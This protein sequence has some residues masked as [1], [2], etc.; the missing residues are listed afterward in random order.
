PLALAVSEKTRLT[1]SLRQLERSEQLQSA[2]FAIADMASSDMD[3]NDMLRELHAI[4]GRF[5]YAENFYIALYDEVADALR[6]IYMVDTIEPLFQ[7]A[8]QV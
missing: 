6:F 1:E 8:E 4:V 7:D 5:M 3:L 2:L